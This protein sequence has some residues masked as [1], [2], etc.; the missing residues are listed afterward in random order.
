VTPDGKRFLFAA[1][2]AASGIARFT[3][4]LNWQATVK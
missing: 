1:P 2:T 4:V 3:I